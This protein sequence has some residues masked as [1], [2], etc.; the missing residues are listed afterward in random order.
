MNEVTETE[1]VILECVHLFLLQ[2]F[3]I[4]PTYDSRR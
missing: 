1:N 4:I 3:T 2:I